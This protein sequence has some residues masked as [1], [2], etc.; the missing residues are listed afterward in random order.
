LYVVI[1]EDGLDIIGILWEC[2]L[3]VTIEFFLWYKSTYVVYV[4]DTDISRSDLSL[5]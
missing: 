2:V 3:V 1:V 4:A 5:P